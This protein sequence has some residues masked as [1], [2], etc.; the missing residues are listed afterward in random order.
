M[1]VLRWPSLP[2]RAGNSWPTLWSSAGHRLAVRGGVGLK[3]VNVVASVELSDDEIDAAA[4]EIRRVGRE[5]VMATAVAIG[6]VL[7]DRLFGGD[8][9]LWRS[10][11]AR[12]TSLRRLAERLHEDDPTAPSLSALQR[13]CGLYAAEVTHRVSALEHV[14]AS[15]VYVVLGL[16]LWAG[17]CRLGVE[18]LQPTPPGAASRGRSRSRARS[19][20][21]TTSTISTARSGPSSSSTGPPAPSPST[22]TPRASAPGRIW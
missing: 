4:A 15:H 7:I 13:A 11:A 3:S 21:T 5:G 14:T 20:R 18:R 12:A 10:G 9:D 16:L 8:V 17:L 1:I 6:R 22:R 19:C 2:C